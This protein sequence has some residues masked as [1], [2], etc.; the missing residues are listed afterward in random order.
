M[1]SI[2]N[3]LEARLRDFGYTFVEV[4]KDSPLTALG[5][6]LV[7]LLLWRIFLTKKV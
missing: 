2:V 6:V 1:F 3:Y 7:F 5:T 4:A